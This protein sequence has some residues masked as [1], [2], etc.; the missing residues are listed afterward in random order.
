MINI[1]ICDDEP[2]MVNDLEIRAKSFFTGTGTEAKISKFYDGTS[3]I[4]SCDAADYDVIFLDIKMDAPDGMETARRLRAR[5]FDGYLI[6]VTILEEL[7]FDAFE[8]SAYDYL[9]KPVSND[10]FLRTMKRLQKRL[11]SSFL[12]VQKEGERRFLAL[13]EIVYCEVLNR[14]IY[15]HTVDGE[16]IDYYDKIDSLESRLKKSGS[17]FFRCHRSFLINFEHL[18]GFGKDTAH[19][20]GGAEIPISRLRR[21]DL[22]TAVI[23]Y[24]KDK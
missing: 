13:N 16:T 2:G 14:K 5:R 12:T 15:I 6:F 10:K 9:V 18:N 17:S 7:V 4:N 24:L 23:T 20:Y 11:D 19:M 21:E 8:V 22:E 1:A 3:L